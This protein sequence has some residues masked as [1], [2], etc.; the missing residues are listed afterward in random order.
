MTQPDLSSGP[1]IV[2][3]QQ[4][5]Q[6]AAAICNSCGET[7]HLVLTQDGEGKDCGDV[8]LN[9]EVLALEFACATCLAA[10]ADPLAGPSP[11]RPSDPDPERL[12]S[13]AT[14]AKHTGLSARDIVRRKRR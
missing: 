9:E 5:L 6:G 2:C 11:E 7:Y 12:P 10:Q 4:A 3:G 1:C 8:W 13:P 14:R